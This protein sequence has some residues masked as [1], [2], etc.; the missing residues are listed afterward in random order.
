MALGQKAV[1]VGSKAS[2]LSSLLSPPQL[3]GD[4]VT[5]VYDPGQGPRLPPGIVRDDQGRERLKTF[6]EYLQEAL[7]GIGS[8]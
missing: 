1:D 2:A 8:S 4:Q 3:Q 6:D 5:G 7:D